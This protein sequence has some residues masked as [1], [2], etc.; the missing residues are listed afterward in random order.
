MTR[1]Q[2]RI[3]EL[4]RENERLK[5]HEEFYPRMSRIAQLKILHER[6]SANP[7]LKGTENS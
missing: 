7:P 2:Q 5:N 1:Q 6:C 4:E 3:E